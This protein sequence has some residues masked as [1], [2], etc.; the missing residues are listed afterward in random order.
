MRQKLN[1][2]RIGLVHQHGRCFIVLRYQYGCHDVMCIH[3]ISAQLSTGL[4]L[5]LAALQKQRLTHTVFITS[6]P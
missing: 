6:T 1:T 4:E 5:D 3:S 2:H